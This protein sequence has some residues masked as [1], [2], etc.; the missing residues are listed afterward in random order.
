MNIKGP[1]N[2]AFLILLL[3]ATVFLFKVGVGSGA[4]RRK[5]PIT[6]SI[7]SSRDSAGS[8]WTLQGPLYAQAHMKSWQRDQAPPQCPVFMNRS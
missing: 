6:T 2:Y 7:R 1:C 8:G 3:Q 4:A 5:G